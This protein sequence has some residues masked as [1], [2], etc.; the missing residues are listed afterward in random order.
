MDEEL[1]EK[2]L[3]DIETAPIDSKLRSLLR[4]VRKLCVSPADVGQADLDQCLEQG[5]S[6]ESVSDAIFVCSLF[7]FYLRLAEGHGLEA[8]PANMQICRTNFGRMLQRRDVAY[9]LPG[10]AEPKPSPVKG[11]CTH[12]LAVASGVSLAFAVMKYT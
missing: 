6:E 1:V 12:L 7:N 11:I 10:S 8:T 4:F 3:A 2:I 9:I 5:W